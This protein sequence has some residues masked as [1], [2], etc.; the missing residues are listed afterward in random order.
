MKQPVFRGS[1]CMALVIMGLFWLTGVA[2]AQTPTPVINAEQSDVVNAYFT[3]SNNAPLIG[4][5]FE[6]TLTVEVPLGASMVNF[7]TL[8]EDMGNLIILEQQTVESQVVGSSTIY[9][10]KMIAVLWEAGI[11]LTPEIPVAVN[12]GGQTFNNLVKSTSFNVPALIE[13]SSGDLALRPAIKPRDLPYFPSYIPVLVVFV[14]GTLLYLLRWLLTRQRQ[15]RIRQGTPAQIAIAELEDLKTQRL[16]A[17]LVYPM[18]A[19][20]VRQ[21]VQIRFGVRAVELTT[22][23]L[24]ETLRLQAGF[25]DTLRKSLRQLLE[26]ADLVKFARFE[27][28]AN[29]TTRLVNFAIKWVRDADAETM[30]APDAVPAYE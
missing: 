15:N 13:L 20:K 26:Q 25:P 16:E 7:P 18:V 9:T 10:Q 19:D 2:L 14:I 22:V 30:A 27:P 4:E 24:M 6:F 5:T 11:Y 17:A 1:W 12:T 29:A 28:D 8:P 21:Y 23:E 3:A